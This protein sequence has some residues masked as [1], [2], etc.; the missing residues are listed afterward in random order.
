MTDAQL[1]YLWIAIAAVAAAAAL[2]QSFRVAY[3]E[4]CVKQMRDAEIKRKGQL[5]IYAP[6]LLNQVDE[7]C[8]H[9]DEMG[10]V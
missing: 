3:L 6:H 1:V 7:V 9:A 4:R 2:Y 8:R 10:I 5:Y